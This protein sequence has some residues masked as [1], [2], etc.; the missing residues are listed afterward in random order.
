MSRFGLS[1]CLIAEICDELNHLWSMAH[2]NRRPREAESYS[3]PASSVTNGTSLLSS[4][5][6]GFGEKMLI[7]EESNHQQHPT[8]QSRHQSNSAAH[9]PSFGQTSPNS[10]N[11]TQSMNNTSGHFSQQRNQ[12]APEQ[13]QHFSRHTNQYPLLNNGYPPTSG[14]SANVGYPP[15][16]G[17]S[18]NVRYPP[19]GGYSANVGYPPTGGHSGNI[20]YPPTSGPSA[21]FGYPP[22]GGY[23]GNIRYPPASRPSTNVGY[24]STSGSSGNVGCSSTDG[25]SSNVRYFSTYGYSENVRHS[26]ASGPSVVAGYSSA[27]GP[28]ANV[29]FPSTGGHSGNVRY[30]GNSEF[31]GNSRHSRSSFAGSNQ[32]TIDDNLSSLMIRDCDIGGDKWKL[33]PSMSRITET[34]LANLKRLDYKVADDHRT[35]FVEGKVGG[36]KTLCLSFT[37]SSR[38]SKRCAPNHGGKLHLLIRP[39]YMRKDLRASSM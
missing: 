18:A 19:T 37:K 31:P 14:P 34:D 8:G 32:D 13:S 36:L 4:C 6:H 16:G 22:T 11:F 15:T 10:W 33:D 28:S 25:Y 23:S 26:S 30:P 9:P 7:I 38:S 3:S 20:R 27:S 29:G 17:P 24:S 12:Q 1:P 39:T 21:N 35:F 5:R 2:Q